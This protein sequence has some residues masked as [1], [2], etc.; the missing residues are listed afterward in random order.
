MHRCAFIAE[1][2][3]YA[4]V[5]DSHRLFWPRLGLG[6]LNQ[7]LNTRGTYLHI[8]HSP[9]QDVVFDTKV[10]FKSSCIP[11][12]SRFGSRHACILTQAYSRRNANCCSDSFPSMT[13]CASFSNTLLA[14][15][16]VFGAPCQDECHLPSKIGSVNALTCSLSCQA[17]PGQSC[18]APARAF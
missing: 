2:S 10:R 15:L 18:A 4:K 9:L 14:S 12:A 7:D 3:R 8:F 1:A 6:F 11:L 17:M 13:I 5:F 16:Q